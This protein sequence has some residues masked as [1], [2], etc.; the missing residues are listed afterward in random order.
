MLLKTDQKMFAIIVNV[1]SLRCDA[2]KD[3][4]KATI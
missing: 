3:I 2:L 1:R 4:P